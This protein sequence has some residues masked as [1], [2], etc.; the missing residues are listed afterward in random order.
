MYGQLHTHTNV[1]V[2]ERM[3]V[4]LLLNEHSWFCIFLK[5]EQK[6]K[7]HVVAKSTDFLNVKPSLAQVSTN[8]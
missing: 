1:A 2:L 3:L 7:E 6:Q 5:A 8:T 4:V